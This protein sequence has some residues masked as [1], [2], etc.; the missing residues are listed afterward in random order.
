LRL[1]MFRSEWDLGPDLVP[2]LDLV[3]TSGFSHL[4]AR[5]LVGQ[6]P[7][8][9]RALGRLWRLSRKSFRLASGW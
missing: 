9:G 1:W 4:V 5:G 7:W 6:S 2:D 3:L 8:S